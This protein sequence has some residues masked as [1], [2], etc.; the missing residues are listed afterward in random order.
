MAI[1]Q[2]YFQNLI[3]RINSLPTCSQEVSVLM[4]EAMSYVNP[5]LQNL[6]QQIANDA[7]LII[8]PTDLISVIAWINKI[9]NQYVIPYEK[10]IAEYAVLASQMEQVI[11]TFEAKVQACVNY[12][13]ILKQIENIGIN[14]LINSET[15][16]LNS[17]GQDI[18][19]SLG[20]N[21]L[22]TIQDV[23]NLKNFI[24]TY[25]TAVV[26]SLVSGAQSLT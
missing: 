14:N 5:L 2:Q 9:I 10:K 22:N 23:V 18:I 13:L 17:A 15:G 19:K 1:N 12:K 11:T 4:G 21:P 26:P 6:E 20:I 8:P 16:L 3:N 7:P 25:S 24:Q